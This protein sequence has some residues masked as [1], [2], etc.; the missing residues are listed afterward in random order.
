MT[1][2]VLLANDTLR[3]HDPTPGSPH[4]SIS[5]AQLPTTPADG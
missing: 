3:P 4:V 5:R 1:Y 2:D